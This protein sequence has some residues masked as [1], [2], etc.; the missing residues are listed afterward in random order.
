MDIDGEDDIK[1]TPNKEDTKQAG[2]AEEQTPT[3]PERQERRLRKHDDE[4]EKMKKLFA[5][6]AANTQKQI[7]EQAERHA[8]EISAMKQTSMEKK[9]F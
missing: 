9:T 8:I 3:S 2:E 6:F 7:N 1:Q 5:I 4:T